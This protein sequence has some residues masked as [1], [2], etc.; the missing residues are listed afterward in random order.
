MAGITSTDIA[1]ALNIATLEL[2]D[3]VKTN[4]NLMDHVT[5]YRNPNKTAN[6]PTFSDYTDL[7]SVAEN[8]AVG[9]TD[10]TGSTVAVTSTRIV[11]AYA[12]SDLAELSSSED[13]G[14]KLGQ[15]LGKKIVTE[16]NKKIWT[17]FDSFS[18]S[19]GDA[20]SGLALT[21]INEANHLLI[22][23]GA[24]GPYTLA[25]TNL[26][27]LQLQETILEDTGTGFALAN[28]IQEFGKP[29]RI[30]G[31]NVAIVTDLASATQGAASAKGALFNREA[32]VMNIAKDLTITIETDR[33]KG[34]QI[35]V[36]D[37]W[38]GVAKAVDG[39]GVELLSLNDPEA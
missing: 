26:Q 27:S 15:Y 6:L 38:C 13:L 25:I 3:F 34:S 37:M 4:A 30:M 31:A 22:G 14:L 11:A 35:L 2:K 32:I 8:V 33:L 5:V 10:A 29:Q 21:D 12:L 16:I 17:L 18:T 1:G 24:V 9:I 39:Y 20:S 23:N 28:Q 7:T 36:A 19:L